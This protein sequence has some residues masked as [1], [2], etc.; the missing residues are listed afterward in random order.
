MGEYPSVEEAVQTRLRD[1]VEAL[2]A[3]A[4]LALLGDA[5]AVHDTRVGCRRA[6]ATR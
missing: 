1:L 3:K 6:R 5:D 2:R 4:P